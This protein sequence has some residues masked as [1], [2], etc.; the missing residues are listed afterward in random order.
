MYTKF[1]MSFWKQDPLKP[2][3]AFMKRGPIL[4]YLPTAC[5]TSETSAPV[6]SQRVDMAFIEEILWD[7]KAFAANLESSA[8]HKLVVIMLSRGTQLA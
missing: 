4:E 5:A 2:T 7:R 6:A 1:R 3:L 8:D